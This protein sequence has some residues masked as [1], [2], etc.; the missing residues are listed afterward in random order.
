MNE[1]TRLYIGTVPFY[2]TFSAF[3]PRRGLRHDAHSLPFR[4]VLEALVRDTGGKEET[5]LFLFR[6]NMAVYTENL[7]KHTQKMSYN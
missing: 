6:D 3:T 2:D 4:V 7:K 1:C 5:K